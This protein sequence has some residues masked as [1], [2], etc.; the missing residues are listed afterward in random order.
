MYLG[1]FQSAIWNRILAETIRRA[2]DAAELFEVEIARQRLPFYRALSP[3][4]A[5]ETLAQPLPLPSARERQELGSRAEFYDRVAAEFGLECRTLRVKYPRD[6]FFS[7]GSRP[8]I[9]APRSQAAEPSD[10]EENPH[11]RKLLLRFDL[12]PGCYATVLIKRLVEAL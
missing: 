11:R 1:A 3:S 6:S 5:A 2:V 7:R 4:T 8:A 10:D 12:P 9:F